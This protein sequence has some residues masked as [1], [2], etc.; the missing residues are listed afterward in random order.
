MAEATP[1]H[2]PGRLTVQECLNLD[3]AMPRA[4]IPVAEL[5]LVGDTGHLMGKAH[6]GVL[7]VL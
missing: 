3:M 2:H 1:H 4:P 7:K 5:G 6:M